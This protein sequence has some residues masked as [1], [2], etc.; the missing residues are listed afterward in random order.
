MPSTYTAEC[1]L[2]SCIILV[3]QDFPATGCH[4]LPNTGNLLAP[5]I[6]QS[7]SFSIQPYFHQYQSILQTPITHY[8]VTLQSPILQPEISLYCKVH[9]ALLHHLKGAGLSRH[10][11]PQGAK[12][13]QPSGPRYPTILQFTLPP[14]CR[15]QVALLHHLKGLG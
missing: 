2:L 14:Y 4:R 15:V 7:C 3:G 5:D 9:L 13:R 1:I 6:H 12:Y 11:L 10:R 8:C